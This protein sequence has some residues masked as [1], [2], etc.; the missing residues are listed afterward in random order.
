MH[1]LFEN[2][3][4]LPCLSYMSD[5]LI[6]DSLIGLVYGD[7]SMTLKEDSE[8]FYLKLPIIDIYAESNGYRP[9]MIHIP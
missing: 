4:S 8:Q 5:L 1:T 9:Y 2:S 3:L 7:N 6:E